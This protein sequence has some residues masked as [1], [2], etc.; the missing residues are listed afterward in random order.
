MIPERHAFWELYPSAF[1][2]TRIFVYVLAV[3]TMAIFAYGIYRKIA[4]WRQGKPIP[5]RLWDNPRERLGG[6]IRYGFLQVKIIKDTYPGLFHSFIFFGF[7]MLFLGTSLTVLDED[8]Y[9]LLTGNKFIQGGFY[10][11]FSLLLDLAGLAAIVGIGLAAFRRYVAKSDRLDNKQEDWILLVLVLSILVTGF[12]SE[13]LRISHD[14]PAF[15][16]Y[17]SPLGYMVASVFSGMGDTGKSLIHGFFW[18]VHLF[19]ALGFIAYIPYSKGM[20]IFAGWFN[21]YTRNLEPKGQLPTIPR[22]MERMEADEEVEM[23]YKAISDLTWKD[24]LMLDACTRCGRCQDVCPAYKTGKALNPKMII[25][26]IRTLMLETACK[27]AGGNGE[28]A[29]GDTRARVLLQ[30]EGGEE[31][32]AIATQVLWDC[33]NCMACMNAC[34]VLVEHIPLIVQMRR[35]LAMEFDDMGKECRNFFKN[36][37]TNANPWGMSPS[38]R[39]EWT[40]GLNVPTV[41]DKPDFE[42]LFWVGCLGAYDQRSQRIAQSLVKIFEA[43]GVNYAILDEME[44]CC[45]D[46]VRRLGNEASFQAMV[47]MTKDALKEAEITLKK[48]ITMC[49]HCFNTLAHDYKEFG[50]DWDVVHHTVFIADLI[51]QGKLKLE[52]G[53]PLSAVVHDS[54]F[55]GRYNDIYEAPREIARAA[56]LN[57][58]TL[59]ESMENGFCC[60]GGGGRTWLEEE[61][62]KVDDKINVARVKQLA[63]TGAKVFLSACPYC[64]MMFDEGTKIKKVNKGDAIW[65][66]YNVGATEMGKEDSVD[67][68]DLVQL[69]DFAELVAEQLP[70]TTPVPEKDA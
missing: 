54:C 69:K 50:L 49:P 59:D 39:T 47:A 18:F 13:A 48:V 57:L 27:A 21:I 40:K 45:G 58:V 68:F 26:D 17:S 41:F 44:L 4:L 6:L 65:K 1:G 20:H 2:W 9:R 24:R 5:N 46:P 30:A 42:Y 19:L 7:A 8:F 33:T 38:D 14:M 29:A 3:V 34:P 32:G 62:E 63:G 37:D 51:K 23:G 22:M 15:E 12:M 61:M 16:K 60:G 31:N 35:E 36:M 28:A 53:N 56:G 67:L 52:K 70:K 55:L 11:I 25:Q 10:V 66:A 43:A 64:M